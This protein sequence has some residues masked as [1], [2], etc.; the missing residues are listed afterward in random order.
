MWR[1]LTMLGCAAAAASA[2]EPTT[3][4][5][6]TLTPIPEVRTSVTVER[7]VRPDLAIV[8]IG[9]S[10]DARTV[11]EAGRML[12]VRADSLRRALQAVGIPRDSTVTRSQ[13]GNQGRV[14][15]VQGPLR[16]APGPR[17]VPP[18]RTLQVRDTSYRVSEVIEVRIRDLSKIGAVLDT[19]LAMGMAQTS[20]PRFLATDPWAARQSATRLASERATE[21]AR[22]IAEA[23]GG[24]IGR[25]LWLSTESE[26]S[27]SPLGLSGVVTTGTQD[28]PG[29]TVVVPNITVRVTVL[30]RWELL[31]KP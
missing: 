5:A 23:S 3:A 10:A 1:T 16:Y 20:Q 8:S 4:P 15:I 24:R 2:Q 17:D 29:S 21:Q 13:Y 26:D 25:T 31:S 9:Y 30:G 18:E 19:A 27:G 28:G 6:R 11:R 7:A 12:A 22:T 14:E